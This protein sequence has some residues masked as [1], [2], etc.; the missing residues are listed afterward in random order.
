MNA[1]LYVEK[2]IPTFR[3]EE[4]P[5]H[6]K[7]FDKYQTGHIEPGTVIGW[8]PPIREDG[9]DPKQDIIWDGQG[10]YTRVTR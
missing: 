1:K 4:H 8:V 6:W 2:G 7:I 9:A 10:M 5:R 3:G